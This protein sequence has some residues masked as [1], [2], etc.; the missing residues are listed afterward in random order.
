MTNSG[1][2]HRVSVTIK[3]TLISHCNFWLCK[4]NVDIECQPSISFPA[5]TVQLSVRVSLLEP[6]KPWLQQWVVKY[7]G[8]HDCTT[9]ALS[10]KYILYH[11]IYCFYS[12]I[13]QTFCR[14]S[15]LFVVHQRIA[16][17]NKVKQWRIVNRDG[18]FNIKQQCSDAIAT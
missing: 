15:F 6:R 18:R 12:G 8:G 13:I 14:R 10:Y 17:A 5:Q 7:Q 16:G 2:T 3:L 4:G 9:T 1:K 11:F